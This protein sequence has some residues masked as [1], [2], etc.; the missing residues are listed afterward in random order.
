MIV[1]RDSVYLASTEGYTLC[2]LHKKRVNGQY[3]YRL[4]ETATRIQKLPEDYAVMTFPEVVA[5][6]G[7]DAVDDDDDDVKP[8]RGMKG[9]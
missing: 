6:Y 3:V 9:K 7:T 8:P 5:K 2:V 4:K 1:F